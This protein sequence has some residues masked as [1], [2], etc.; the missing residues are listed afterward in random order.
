M[1][2]SHDDCVDALRPFTA[3]FCLGRELVAVVTIDLRPLQVKCTMH[4]L[5]IMTTEEYLPNAILLCTL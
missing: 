1:F 4:S 2:T 5:P 3:E